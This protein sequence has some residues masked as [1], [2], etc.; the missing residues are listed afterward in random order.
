LLFILAKTPKSSRVFRALTNPQNFWLMIFRVSNIREF[1]IPVATRRL[2]GAD[3]GNFPRLASTPYERR[4]FR[5]PPR[6]YAQLDLFAGRPTDFTRT[7]EESALEQEATDARLEPIG[8]NDFE[9]LANASP[10][11]AGRTH[12]APLERLMA[13]L[14]FAF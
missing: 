4:G 6:N 7:A 14:P 8:P 9:T 11:D 12:R 13:D 2:V 1:L 5:R 10:E 3:G